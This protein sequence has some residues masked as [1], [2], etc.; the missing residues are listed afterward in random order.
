[1]KITRKII[2]IDES[3][4]DGC[5]LCIP[6]CHEQAIQL[7][8]TPNGKKAR[9]V[10]EMFCDGLGACLGR[11]PTGA[12]TITE[13]EADAFDETATQQHVA[14][15]NPPQPAQMPRGGCPSAR[16][17]QW[18]ATPE[19]PAAQAEATVAPRSELRQWPV[20]LHL[21]P[22]NAPYFKNADLV[23]AADCAPFAYANFH[24]EV[25]KGD[26]KALVIG[27]PK[28]DDTGAYLQKLTQI[29]ALSHLQSITIV[30]MEVPC[31]FGLVRLVQQAISQ[32]GADV[33]V[34][35]VTISIKGEKLSQ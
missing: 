15:R 14:Q 18:D 31:C 27:C 32:A 4:C 23:I 26:S 24:Q 33:P 35:I 1:M 30:N 29:A 17:V 19:T 22:P 12:L 34:N 25:L 13:R 3:L 28:L 9:L 21:V 10:K 5:G 16:M 20:Q 2:N 11:C 7:V 6:S 8:D